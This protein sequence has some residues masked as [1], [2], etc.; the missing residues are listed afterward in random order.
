MRE[1]GTEIDRNLIREAINIHRSV[2]DEVFKEMPRQRIT[3]GKIITVAPLIYDR[4]E[5][6]VDKLDRDIEYKKDLRRALNALLNLNR[7]HEGDELERVTWEKEQ[8]EYNIPP[9]GDVHIPGG[10]LQIL[11]HLMKIV[12][13]ES[14]KLNTE[15]V[16]I[17]WASKNGLEVEVIVKDG[18]KFKANHV[19]VTCSLGYLKKHH[20]SLF[21]PKLPQEKVDAI[22]SLAIGRVN[23]IFLEFEKGL[24]LPTNQNVIF[25]W[26]TKT[27]DKDQWYKRIFGFE[28]VFTK[29][30]TY[31]GWI[32]GEGAEYMERLSDAEIAKTSTQLL[33]KFLGK[34]DLPEPKSVLVT[35]WCRNP[36]ALGTYTYQTKNMVP[37]EQATLS[38][39]LK[40]PSGKPLVQFAGEALT[41]ACTHG[42]RDSGL[43][44]AERLINLYSNIRVSSK[45]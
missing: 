27:M 22:H 3:S 8:S 9:G 31:I 39:P 36:Y 42:A 11:E 4:L 19:I 20:E 25:A 33:R 30:N 35:R 2:V 10:Y 24:P 40:A 41:N 15:V 32:S 26:E 14:L 43:K 23:K 28:K 12:P 44:E 34:P 1:D 45:L 13:K 18:S 29:N 17:N 37:G 6:E 16:S 21:K 7:F 38:E 5:E